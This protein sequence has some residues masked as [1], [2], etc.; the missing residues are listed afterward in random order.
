MKSFVIY[1]NTRWLKT[2]FARN[3]NWQK[4]T[5]LNIT[6][7]RLLTKITKRKEKKRKEK[8]GT[9]E[10][11]SSSIRN[12]VHGHYLMLVRVG[13]SYWWLSINSQLAGVS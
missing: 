1:D 5:P 7:E 3:M 4:K 2:L 9:L 10:P 11:G 6:C 13:I 8:K 12:T